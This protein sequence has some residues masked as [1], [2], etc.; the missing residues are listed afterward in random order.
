[1]ESDALAGQA[2]VVVERYLLG[3]GRGEVVAG[4][5]VERLYGVVAERGRGFP[6]WSAAL[7][8]LARSPGD[9]SARREVAGVVASWCAEDGRFADAVRA[10][11]AD[12]S[13]SPHEVDRPVHNTLRDSTVFGPSV[14]AGTLD[15]NRGVIAGGDVDQSRHRSVRIGL[16]GLLAVLLLGSAGAIGYRIGAYGA[17]GGGPGGG[18]VESSAP[19][20]YDTPEQTL[21]ELIKRIAD[22]DAEG[23]CRLFLPGG[24]ISFAKEQGASDCRSAMEIVIGGVTDPEG[25]A[26]HVLKPSGKYPG[27][28]V[29]GNAAAAGGSCSAWTGEVRTG[30]SPAHLGGF[31]LKKTDDGW[32]INGNKGLS[33]LSSCGG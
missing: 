18:G 11:V 1:M 19:S 8:R 22:E 33:S 26:G 9:E 21:Q 7:E 32:L 13:R 2:A 29:R 27:V 15:L 10:A 31:S 24:A 20:G 23:A 12:A 17:G 6:W 14:Q 28:E 16:G 30:I 3:V 5:A 4:S 25:F